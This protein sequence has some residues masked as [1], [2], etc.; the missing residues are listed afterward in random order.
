METLEHRWATVTKRTEE[1]SREWAI[2]ITMTWALK[3]SSVRV[4]PYLAARLFSKLNSLRLT[5]DDDMEPGNSYLEDED[6]FDD[7]A[8]DYYGRPK[9][10]QSWGGGGGKIGM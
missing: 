5:L 9:N 10:P 8:N 7:H 4:F 6:D 1:V 3:T 2:P